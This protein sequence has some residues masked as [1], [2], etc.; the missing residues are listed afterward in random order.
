M[1]PSITKQVEGET[2]TFF[3]EGVVNI[4]TAP[5]LGKEVNELPEVKA[6]IFDME[7]VS[8]VASAG[9]RV[10]IQAYKKMKAA[11]GSMKV[12]HVNDEVM[13]VCRFT[14]LADVMDIS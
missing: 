4:Q 8:M 2:C 7:K 13:K 3:L 9:F 11:G 10:L 5:E 14:G 6:L 1:S 12:I